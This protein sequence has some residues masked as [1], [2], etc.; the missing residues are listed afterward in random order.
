[1]KIGPYIL[2]CVSLILSLFFIDKVKFISEEVISLIVFSIVPSLFP[3]IF[4]L[5]LFLTSNSLNVFYK[6]LSKTRLGRLVFKIILIILGILLGMPAFAI[7]ID[8]SIEKKIINQQEGQQIINHFGF[9]SFPFLYGVI[10]PFFD[11]TQRILIISIIF[12][13]A[14]LFYLLNYAKVEKQIVTLEIT[15]S[16]FSNSFFTSITKTIKSLTII[17]STM[18]VFSLPLAWSS[19]IIKEPFVYFIGG[20]S[21]FSY[22][23]VA[24]AKLQDNLSLMLL[25][26]ILSFSSLSVLTQVQHLTKNISIRSFLKKRAFLALFNTLIMFI[27]LSYF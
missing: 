25:I 12:G 4:L 13:S 10:L 3:F 6:N 2:I 9:V 24:L 11:L 27:M 19:N 14:I 7:L 5:N 17:A 15:P 21:E 8:E 18:L 20:L 1:M 16:S 22:S 23:S 26:F